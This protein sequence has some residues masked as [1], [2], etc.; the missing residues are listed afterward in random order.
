MKIDALETATLALETL[1][2]AHLET[3]N[4]GLSSAANL[5]MQHESGGSST[6][7]HLHSVGRGDGTR[8]NQSSAF[9]AFQ[10]I[11]STRKQ[12]MG[13]DYQSTDFN[14]LYAAATHY[15]SDRY[16]GWNGAQ[17]FWKKHHWY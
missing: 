4:G 3:V 9:G 15:V 10:M 16:G 8:G 7:G 12:Y 2:D 11:Q 14:K 13:A 6:A 5:F 17:S 1:D